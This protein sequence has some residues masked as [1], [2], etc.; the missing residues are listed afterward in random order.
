MPRASRRRCYGGF[1][2][3]ATVKPAAGSGKTP[4]SII[5]RRFIGVWSAHRHTPW[6]HLLRYWDLPNLEVINRDAHVEKCADEAR[7]RSARCSPAALAD[8]TVV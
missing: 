3:T 4:K 8:R 2:R 5:V 1:R 6:P 7:D